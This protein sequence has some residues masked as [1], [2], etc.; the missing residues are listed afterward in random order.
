MRAARVVCV[1]EEEGRPCQTV[2]EQKGRWRRHL[3]KVLNVM[4]QFDK[5]E[6][7]KAE[8]L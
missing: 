8:T 6:L 7:S 4:S 3:S 1:N 5:E 2:G